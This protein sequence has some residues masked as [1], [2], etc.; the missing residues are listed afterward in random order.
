MLVQVI[1]GVALGQARLHSS[2]V[3]VRRKDPDVLGLAVP[4]H[5]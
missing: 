4:L 1:W 5:I 2:P 3:P